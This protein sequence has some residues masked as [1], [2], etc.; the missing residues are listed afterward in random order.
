MTALRQDQ[1]SGACPKP[2]FEILTAGAWR[3]QMASLLK[4]VFPMPRR[5]PVASL[6]L[7]GISSGTVGA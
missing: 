6:R 4:S 3:L 7:A 2:D 5:W 1:T